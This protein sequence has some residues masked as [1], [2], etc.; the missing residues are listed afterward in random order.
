MAEGVEE[1]EVEEL[2]PEPEA[3]NVAQRYEDLGVWRKSHEWVLAVYRKTRSFPRDE[4]FG[5]TSQL[6]RS[7][8]SV[9]MNIVEGFS[10]RGV[11]DKLRFYNIA[12]ASLN[13]AHYQL[14]L[15]HDLSYAN[16]L[17]LRSD[18]GDISRM[19]IAY[20]RSI[21]ANSDL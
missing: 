5:L 19:L 3:L 6:R 10:R 20:T 12:E 14:R 15:A 18:V 8:G 9:P 21:R 7:A 11:T 13:E 16:T 4:D 17:D 1:V 2:R